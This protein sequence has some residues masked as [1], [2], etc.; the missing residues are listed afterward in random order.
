MGGRVTYRTGESQ[1][2]AGSGKGGNAFAFPRSRGKETG[3]LLRAPVQLSGCGGSSCADAIPS[4]PALGNRLGGGAGCRWMP[5]RSLRG[6]TGLRA[7]SQRSRRRWTGAGRRACQAGTMQMIDKQAR[8]RTKYIKLGH[9]PC[10]VTCRC[11]FCDGRIN[12]PETE[13]LCSAAGC[14]PA[15][16]GCFFFPAGHGCFSPAGLG[17]FFPAGHRGSFALLQRLE[18]KARAQGGFPSPNTSAGCLGYPAWWV[19][20]VLQGYPKAPDPFPV[21]HLGRGAAS[22]KSRPKTLPSFPAPCV[23]PCCC[24]CCWPRG[25]AAKPSEGPGGGG[26]PKLGLGIF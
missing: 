22:P 19:P 23:P 7:L 3:F 18:E 15:G 10:I 2:R 21:C 16:L 20:P 1:P 5:G 9:V 25:P 13:G 24:C 4:L 14:F 12:G 8:T 6:D 26:K 11:A 17:C